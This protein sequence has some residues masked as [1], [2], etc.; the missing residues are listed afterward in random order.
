MKRAVPVI[1]ALTLAIAA[2]TGGEPARQ[3]GVPTVKLLAQNL[4]MFPGNDQAIR[5]GFQTG[6][7]SANII[8]DLTPDTAALAVCP[9]TALGAELPLITTCKDVG[10]GVREPINSTG[11]AA[12][13]LVLSGVPSASAN[14]RLEYD[15][16][17]HQMSAQIPF[18]P[19]P[20]S[21]QA[22]KDNGCN[23]F[24]ELTPLRNGAF[25][26]T[27][28]WKG[29]AG[30]LE[31]LEG[32]VLGRSQTATG[33]PYR[34]AARADGKPPVS[35]TSRLAQGEYALA[36]TQPIGAN[37]APLTDVFLSASWP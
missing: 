16:G 25:T 30:T 33:I 28:T 11:L 20:E 17:G 6:S 37:A 8:V 1:F 13:A 12:V 26:A 21:A 29:P 5:I 14:V 18:L 24:F 10:S 31:L 32:S 35:I 34:E 3:S 7:S 2:C 19:A 27:A 9:L 4:S 36:V 23:P 22:C 15:D